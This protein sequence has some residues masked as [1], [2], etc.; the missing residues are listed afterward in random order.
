MIEMVSPRHQA[1]HEK[2][3]VTTAT[4]STEYEKESSQADATLA[5]PSRTVE[6]RESVKTPPLPVPDRSIAF[7][8]TLDRRF[9]I[10]DIQITPPPQHVEP[11]TNTIDVSARSLQ[12]DAVLCRRSAIYPASEGMMTASVSV[13]VDEAKIGPLELPYVVQKWVNGVAEVLRGRTWNEVFG[14][15]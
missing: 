4:Q 12:T 8:S 1:D 13:V 5:K 3:N 9:G 7:A 14:Q 11:A 15:Q 10:P 2:R 6:F